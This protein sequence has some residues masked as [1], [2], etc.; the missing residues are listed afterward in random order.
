V[1]L[2]DR[3]FVLSSNPGRLRAA[4]V[5]DLSRPRNRRSPEFELLVDQIY[6]I[7]T[8][9]DTEEE[10]T[11][12]DRKGP[13]V[14]PGLAS[15]TELPLPHASVGGLAG[16]LEI[17][18][19]RG[20][21]DDLPELAKV[22]TFDVDDLL[23]LVDAAEL[24]GFAETVNAD[25]QITPLG[26]EWVGADIL[27]SKEL[28]ADA[29]YAR[30]PLVRA[31]TRALHSCSDRTLNERFFLDLLGRGFPEEEANAQLDTAIDWGRYAELF[32]FDANTGELHLDHRGET[33]AASDSS[34]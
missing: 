9:K 31:V 20:G 29:A 26:K 1:Q 33:K 7:M 11:R 17:V 28:F 25:L 4:I 22:L 12:R 16:L 21:R 10:A 5:D 30:A 8:G 27:T 34:S 23:P 24:L 19:S 15:P 3:I 13:V 32:D 14:E 18:N 6:G 2:A